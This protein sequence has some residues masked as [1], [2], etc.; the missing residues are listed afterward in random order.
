MSYQPYNPMH[1]QAKAVTQEDMWEVLARHTPGFKPLKA[2]GSPKEKLRIREPLMWHDV[3][4]TGP[5]EKPRQSGYI[6][7]QCGRFSIDGRVVK[8]GVYHYMAWLRKEPS[9]ESVSLGIR[10][11]RKEAEHLCDLENQRE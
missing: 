11:T 6:L 3:V 2:G 1:G 7:S 9:H 4:W 10:L 5:K 8:R